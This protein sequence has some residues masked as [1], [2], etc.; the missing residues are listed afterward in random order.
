ME[1]HLVFLQ[2]TLK[3]KNALIFQLLYKV[4]FENQDVY[5]HSDSCFFS[6][7]CCQ[8]NQIHVILL[9]FYS[10]FDKKLSG[11]HVF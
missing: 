10:I 4:E 9:I 6:W 3:C 8:I 2:A 11:M 1:A 7:I 5:N